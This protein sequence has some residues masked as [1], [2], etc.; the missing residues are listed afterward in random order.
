[1]FPG[2]MFGAGDA[3]KEAYVE[4]L[5]AEIETAAEGMDGLVVDEVEFWGGPAGSLMG[6]QLARIMRVVKKHYR[7]APDVRIH[8]HEAPGGV[9]VDYAG[10][11]KSAHVEWIELEVLCTDVAA[12]KALGLPPSLGLTVGCFQVAHFAGAP[13]MGICGP[14]RSLPAF[15]ATPPASWVSAWGPRA[16]S[17]ASGS[18]P[19]T[20]WRCTVRTA[21]TSRL[22]RG[23][24][25]G[26]PRGSL[27]QVICPAGIVGP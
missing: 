25:R 3:A 4:A 19:R 22:L 6:A 12:L 24:F 27:H 26:C 7:L 9:T 20:T 23:R 16:A 8:L 18:R 2:V 13:A 5:V 14:A 11:C 21:A 15:W 17:T 10:F 1:M